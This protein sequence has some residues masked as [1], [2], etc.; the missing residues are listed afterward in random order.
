MRWSPSPFNPDAHCANLVV[1]ESTTSV[2]LGDGLGRVS[3]VWITPPMPVTTR[4]AASAR[5][6]TGSQTATS[7][8]SCPPSRTPQL[9][10]STSGAVVSANNQ[11][12]LSVSHWTRATHPFIPGSKAVLTLPTATCN[13]P[14]VLGSH[15]QRQA[16]E[17][18]LLEARE[19]VN[20]VNASPSFNAG[21]PTV[22]SQAEL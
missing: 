15:Q 14:L 17:V 8:Q 3:G 16:S 1:S 18:R 12:S 9:R 13:F 2:G 22:V 10:Q 20:R 6:S 4:G 19:P 21:C 7:V 11:I 5:C